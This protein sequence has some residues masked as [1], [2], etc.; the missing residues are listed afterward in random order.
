[1]CQECHHVH[2]KSFLNKL[3]KNET[4]D[5]IKWDGGINLNLIKG[6][7]GPN[8]VWKKKRRTVLRNIHFWFCS[9]VSAMSFVLQ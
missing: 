1:M 9:A 6:Q 8:T 3:L 2:L 4:L 7:N 5:A